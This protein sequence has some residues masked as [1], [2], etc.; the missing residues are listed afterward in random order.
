MC[1]EQKPSEEIMYRTLQKSDLSAKNYDGQ[2]ILYEVIKHKSS[3]HLVEFLLKR[4]INIGA[5]DKNGQT[6]RDF[7]LS[8]NKKGG[9]YVKMIDQYVI[10]MVKNSNIQG[11]EALILQGYDHLLDV[12]DEKEELGVLSLA[13]LTGSQY[14]VEL[15]T[16]VEKSKVW[17]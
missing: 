3:S 14:M 8:L 4:G 12:I 16:K 9:K 10:D 2:T 13:R 11:I 17:P 15:L 1:G 6:A 5:R 7:A